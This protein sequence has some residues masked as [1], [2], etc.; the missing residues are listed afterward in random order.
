MIYRK[1]PCKRMPGFIVV[2]AAAILDHKLPIIDWSISWQHAFA[3]LGCKAFLVN[4]D[5]VYR[6]VGYQVSPV[7]AGRQRS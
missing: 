3:P 7:Y 2:P 5:Y 4:V 6:K 1:N